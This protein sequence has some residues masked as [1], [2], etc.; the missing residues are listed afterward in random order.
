MVKSL[1]LRRSTGARYLVTMGISTGKIIFDETI[2]SQKIT[3]YDSDLVIVRYSDAFTVEEARTII[4]HLDRMYHER[5][6]LYGL[7]EVRRLNHFPPTV[8]GERGFRD[9]RF[10]ALAFAG[11]SF[12]TRV[13]ISMMIRAGK[14]LKKDA[15]SHPIEFFQTEPE[16]LKWLTAQDNTPGRHAGTSAL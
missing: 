8:R 14:A 7:A 16:A 2:G 13:T 12:A 6:R 10:T 9:L 11:M 5:G 4:A 3:L 1:T 15:F